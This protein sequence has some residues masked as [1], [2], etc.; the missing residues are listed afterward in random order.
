MQKAEDDLKWKQILDIF[1]KDKYLWF[2][3]MLLGKPF[4]HSAVSLSLGPDL[5]KPFESKYLGLVFPENFATVTQ[6]FQTLT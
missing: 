4:I 3:L 5:I 6:T 1:V 2:P